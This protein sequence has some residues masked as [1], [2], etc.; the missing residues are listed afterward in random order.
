MTP[1]IRMDI[2]KQVMWQAKLT[3][4]NPGMAGSRIH[5][6]IETLAKVRRV[7]P[8]DS[9]TDALMFFIDR[10]PAK[11]DEEDKLVVEQFRGEPSRKLYSEFVL[12]ILPE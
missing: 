11:N 6:M 2:Y 10:Y 5:H 9:V 3:V 8:E 4:E 7:S 1:E 12:K